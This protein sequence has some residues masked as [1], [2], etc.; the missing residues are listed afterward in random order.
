M[1]NKSFSTTFIFSIAPARGYSPGHGFAFLLTPYANLR[2]ALPAQ[3][4]GLLNT[5]ADKSESDHL[6]AVEFDT[7]DNIE[8]QDINDNHVGVDLNS[9][10]STNST[11]AGYWIGSH[12]E[13][14]HGSF[15]FRN[16]SL[17]SGQNIQAWIEY[18]G[19]R[20]HLNIT[21]SPAGYDRPLRPL[22]SQD[23]DLSDLFID[24]MY[25]GFSVSTGSLVESN[26]ILAWS[27]S[28]SGRVA[29]SLDAS[30]LPSFLPRNIERSRL[31]S[32]G[33]IVTMSGVSIALLALF[34]LAVIRIHKNGLGHKDLNVA[35]KGFSEE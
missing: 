29:K 18:D 33:F 28:T 26:F 27:L 32:R 22:L 19:A 7:C 23:M 4:L 31:K 30:N 9:L 5:T 2:G 17:N 14:A 25:A 1:K 8:L 11:P 10:R 24:D 16:L 6:F 13:G 34:I 21:I 35:T 15:Q 20:K 3:Y 12:N